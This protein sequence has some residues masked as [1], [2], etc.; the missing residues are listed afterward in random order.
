MNNNLDL[1]E[2]LLLGD[3]GLLIKIR[4][5]DGLDKEKAEQIYKVLTDLALEWKDRDSIPKKAAD[6]FIDIY[7]A[8]LNQSDYYSEEKAIEIMDCC[9]KMLDLIRRCITE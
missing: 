1:L 5:A 8:M 3:D 6:L 7:P 2:E 9:D 4:S